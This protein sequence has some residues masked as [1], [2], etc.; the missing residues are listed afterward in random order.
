[1]GDFTKILTQKSD[2]ELTEIG[3]SILEYQSLFIIDFFSELDKRGL[4]F[5]YKIL[6]SNSHLIS[7]AFKIKDISDTKYLDI[8]LKEIDHRKLTVQ[9]AQ[10]LK[11]KS[12]EELESKNKR[13]YYK[14]LDR[15]LKIFFITCLVIGWILY[16]E[17]VLF[18][19]KKKN[20][21]EIRYELPPIK[22]TV[23][24][25]EIPS[26]KSTIDK[27]MEDNL[28]NY[29]PKQEQS[30]NIKSNQNSTSI[31]NNSKKINVSKSSNQLLNDMNNAPSLKDG[32][33]YKIINEIEG[34]QKKA[35]FNNPRYQLNKSLISDTS[36]N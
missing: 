19:S 36:T 10:I 20:K 16:K 4:L 1:M 3:D 14:L 31:S 11:N 5:D 27:S 26:I 22:Y 2:L 25:N 21:Q 13:W 29:Y 33:S 35:I 6:I 7:I 9:Y 15:I 32:K 17:G 30:I 12:E 8:L 28:N 23:P 18:N 24:K 34:N